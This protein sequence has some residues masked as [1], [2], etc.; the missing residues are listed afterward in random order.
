M[1]IPRKKKLP[2]AVAAAVRGAGGKGGSNSGGSTRAPVEAPDSLRSRQYATVLDLVS[3]G[4]IQGLVNGLQSVYFDGVP[5]QNGDGSFN[6]TGVVVDSRTGTQGQTY[7]EGFPS[8][9]NEVA[10]GVEVTKA[11]SV[12]RQITNVNVNAARITLAIPQLTSA[13][14]TTGDLSGTSV[15]IA[16]DLQSNGGGFVQQVLDTI[17]GKTTTRYNRSYRVE[18]TGSPPWD[19]RVRRITADSLT[20][21]VVNRTFFSSYTEIIDQK[22][23]FPN[24]AIVATQVDAQQFS[25]IPSRAFHIRGMR[26]QVP[27]NYNATTRVY[28]GVWDG[29]FQIAWTDNPAW[30]FYDMLTSERYGLGA[31]VDASQ[32]D[33]WSLYEI[34]QYCDELVSDGFGGLE[35]RFTC[36][37]YLQERAEAYTVINNMASI[38]RGMAYWSSGAITAVQ[39]RPSDAVM[40]F[41]RS[42]VIDG[43]FKYEGSARNT[44]HTVAIV[45]WNDPS[46]AYQQKVEYVEDLAGIARYGVV[47]GET[48]AFG[49]T[50]RGQAHRVGRWMLYSE[51][52]ETETVTFR[53]GL[54]GIL[55]YPGAIIKTSD[56][57]RSGS[58]VGGRVVSA[59]TTAVTI[60]SPVTI[61]LGPVYT[62][63][64]MAADG[65][66][67]SRDLGNAPGSTS[68]L[69]PVTPFSVAPSAQAAW[70]LAASTLEPEVWRVIAVTQPDK[71]TLQVMALAYNESKFDAVEQDLVLEI[72]TT[73][74]IGA[75]PD[76]PTNLSASEQLCLAG[77]NAVGTRV[78]LSWE[79]T[80][81]RY[82]V[83][84]RGSVGNWVTL[85]ELVSQTIEIDDLLPDLYTFSVKQLNA[86]GIPSVA[87]TLTQEIYGKTAPPAD[88]GGFSV[89]KSA[90]FGL[91]QWTPAADL[92][93]QVGGTIVIRHNP[94]TTG[95]VWSDGIIVGEF[96]G[97]DVQG[98]VPLM[99]GTYMAK[100][101]DSSGNYSLNA[102][103][104]VATE[105]LVTGFTT[106]GSSI[107]HPTFTGA[108]SN[109][110]LV[111]TSIQLDSRA[112]VD[113]M[114]A[115]VDDWP[116]IDALGGVSATGSYAFD[117]Y[118]DLLS[119][120]TRRFEA[121]IRSTG[122]DTGDLIDSRLDNVDDWGLFDGSSVDDVN[123]VLYISTTPD[124]PAGAPTWGPYAPFFVADFTCRAARFRLDLA[125][126][127]ATHNIAVDT[128]R[129]DA[130]VPV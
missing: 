3:E 31:F 45:A 9:Q 28:T 39:D 77:V 109:V 43:Q 110:A 105:G 53:T 86:L 66:L 123:A 124:D 32:I 30:C 34:A 104:F 93:V 99:T 108:K 44:R 36:N 83:A 60:D 23:T 94:N 100:A 64:V 119:S 4:E 71:S 8:S 112:T 56:P 49:C 85:P 27:S 1:R 121:D 62:L 54:E 14:V 120:T 48:L 63:Y 115:L 21:N 95:V 72:P 103:S 22:L 69:N 84:Y 113:S 61:T 33:K 55:V 87:A 125:S 42:N 25:G 2:L 17:A 90:G 97:S 65:T 98:F 106:V 82:V 57:I 16:I 80:T 75:M 107:Q 96:T 116:F 81:G 19:I 50:S 79:G 58:R 59:T 20:T 24:S 78:T 41:N 92:D 47:Q 6:F 111:G 73:S 102:V 89:I 37:L 76:P 68:V 67:Q 40:L 51:R 7:I 117:T 70:I 5:L 12:T 18:L 15:Q 74:T 114:A 10:V 128:L 126:A 35:P 46:D 26:V 129:V 118:L 88:V 101:V 38:F 91:A 130:K 13:N 127:Q 29:N 11:L 122:F 52:M